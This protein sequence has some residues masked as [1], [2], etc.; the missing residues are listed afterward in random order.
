[1]RRFLNALALAILFGTLPAFATTTDVR[2]LLSHQ[3]ARPGDTVM[4]GI[5]LR[6]QPG[7][8]TYWINPGDSGL[9][10]TIKWDLPPGVTAGQIQWPVP[11]KL[12]TAPL[13]TY[14]YDGEATLLVPL[15]INASAP[16]G[17]LDV[18]A[19]VSWQE[20]AEQCILGNTTVNGQLTIGSESK[21]SAD[22]AFL[23][24][25]KAKLPRTESAPIFSAHWEKEADSR[26]LLIEWTAPDKPAEADF[27]PYAGK[28]FE[29]AGDTERLPDADGKVRI[30][31]M[32]TKS[33]PDWPAH[34]E[35]LLLTKASKDSPPVAYEVSLTPDESVAVA[36][37][38]ASG[39]R[40]SFILELCFA[41][42]GGLILNIMPCVLPVIAL[43]VLG[44]VNQAREEPG[45]VRMLGVIYGLGV[46]VSF[47]I[48]AGIAITVQHAGGLAGW[49]TAFQNPQFR[50]IIT[51]L[52]T[53]VALNLFGVFEVTLSGKAMG[54]AAE[55]TAKQGTA[56]AFFNG[57]LATLLA[58]PCTA[59]F[60]APAIA[61]AFTQPPLIILLMFTAVACG[62]A[63]P[64]VLLCWQPA[65]LKFLPRP[66]LWMQRFK[67]AMGFPMLATA[68]W[69]FWVTATRMGKTG[70]L[71][72][73]LFL[74]VVA[75]AAWIWGEFVQ[76][77]T[78][79]AGLAILIS[80]LFVAGAYGFILEKQLHWRHPNSVEKDAIVWQ[81]WSPEAVQKA[82]S[83]GH[84]VLVDFTADTCL[85]CKV[86]L[87]TSID[88]KATRDKLREM[89]A[90][91]L[92]GNFTDEDPAIAR[93]LKQFDRPGV[94][95]VLVYPSNKDL[96]PIVLPPVLTPS[97]VRDALD[98]A[99]RSSGSVTA[100]AR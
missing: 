73:G 41:F 46:L 42:L 55:L 69:L 26:P 62:L 81:P 19:K 87:I 4:A 68:V 66:G 63:A 25:A 18:K 83:E 48:L 65:W 100:S 22:A 12:V 23:E 21:P 8:H 96:P 9:A 52:I 30:R 5:S 11:E 77:G 78:K 45:R 31:K 17:P 49:S 10:T 76:R 70:V 53:L 94:P 72:F 99:T 80:L 91:T 60:L 38:P 88:I 86:N 79:R 15:K 1:M 2:L 71:W 47:L 43:K 85:N 98:K 36:T 6:M 34:I 20:C 44:F 32:V 97:L 13:T 33:G 37:T 61:F 93:E 40:P 51:V 3:T 95:L 39:K 90:I 67:V 82:R 74:V 84:P 54:A 57:V 64:F 89:N 27:F 50:V 14:V 59:P 28:K 24:A 7:W 56:G 75:L 16:P 35:G 92:E 58:T 29:V